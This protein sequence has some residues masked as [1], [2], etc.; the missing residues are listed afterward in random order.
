MG[1]QISNFDI[2]ARYNGLTFHIWRAELPLKI[3]IEGTGECGAKARGDGPDR[4]PLHDV[5]HRR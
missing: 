3:E 5:G 4:D 2:D 1:G